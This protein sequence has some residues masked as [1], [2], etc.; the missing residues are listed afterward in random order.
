[1]LSNGCE[2]SISVIIPVRNRAG[3]IERCLNSVLAQTFSPVEV[4][5]VD[6]GSTDNTVSVI[7]NLANSLVRLISLPISSG[8][9]AA[10]NA[11]II[12]AAGDWIAFQ[13]SDDEWLPNKLERQVEKL[14]HVGSSAQA[15]IHVD[16]WRVDK[17]GGGKSHM[18]ISRVVGTDTFPLLLK[19]RSPMYQGLL[20]SKFALFDIGLLDEKVPAHQE[21][22]TSLRLAEKCCFYHVAEPLFN[23]YCGSNDAISANL[24]Q[25]LSGHLYIIEKYSKKIINDCGSDVHDRHI[26]I[27]MIKAMKLKKKDM[28]ISLSKKLIKLNFKNIFY[29]ILPRIVVL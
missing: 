29:R 4:I 19:S 17:R 6:D 27:C 5:V 16:G 25:D 1:M 11:G 22:D 3:T 14:R 10:R 23:Y 9:Q 13:D 15:V 24:S 28:V 7:R 2:F 26:R 12:A 18:D 8:A 20:V 21:W